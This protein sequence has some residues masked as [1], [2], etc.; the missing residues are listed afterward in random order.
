[1]AFYNIYILDSNM[2]RILLRNMLP[3]EEDAKK[4]YRNL[5]NDYNCSIFVE[6]VERVD[7]TEW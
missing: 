1:M 7:I 6:K 2:N 3:S 4:A 5:C